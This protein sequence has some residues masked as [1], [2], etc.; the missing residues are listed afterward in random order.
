MTHSPILPPPFVGDDGPSLV[1][2]AAM[3]RAASITPRSAARDEED[4]IVELAAWTAQ[5]PS[6]SPRAWSAPP[7]ADSR[8]LQIMAL[9]SVWLVGLGIAAG[10]LLTVMGFA[11]AALVARSRPVGALAAPSRDDAV[12]AVSVAD[13]PRVSARPD[14][15]VSSSTSVGAG[16]SAA[17]GDGA[18]ATNSA[19]AVPS[20]APASSARLVW[21]P[22]ARTIAP[23]A[24]AGART[25]PATRTDLVI[26]P[27]EVA[28]VAT[29]DSGLSDV[30]T[31]ALVVAAIEGVRPQVQ[32]CAA[33]RHGAA[34]VLITVRSNGRVASA[35]VSGAFAGTPEGSCIARAVRE[36][37][38]PAFAQPTFAIS[39]PFA[40]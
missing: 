29:A 17:M 36:A 34:E 16:S 38:F 26:A 21:R 15:P 7:R 20:L 10:G 1:D 13:P 11:A 8:G 14:P 24:S 12:V 22:R 31:R 9:A 27:V 40:L 2:L 33:S 23:G 32:A 28:I 39:Y 5:S 25:A 4:Q 6:A 19:P 18:A 3:G 35:I 30:P 37:Q